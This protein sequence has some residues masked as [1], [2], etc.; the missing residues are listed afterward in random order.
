MKNM[1]ADRGGFLYAGGTPALVQ[2]YL[3][4]VS[5]AIFDT[6]EAKTGGGT[7]Y[8]NNVDMYLLMETAISVYHS[9]TTQG[10]GG[11]FFIEKIDYIDFR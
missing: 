7:F 1:K 10:H 9:K 4:F 5:S 2:S 6:M 11:V 8:I 3:S